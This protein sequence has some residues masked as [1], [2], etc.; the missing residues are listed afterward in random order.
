MV[1]LLQPYHRNFGKRLIK[2]PKLYFLDTGLASYLLGFQDSNLLRLSPCWGALFETLVITEWI[3]SFL[4]QGSQPPLYYWRSSDGIEVDLL[5]EGGSTFQAFEIKGGET[6]D[7]SFK[8]PLLKF[9]GLAS[10]LGPASPQVLANIASPQSL[11]QGIQ[12]VPWFTP[13]VSGQTDGIIAD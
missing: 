1:F 4:N 11:G 10:P 12:A 9:T 7:P 3:K 6:L 13:F 8:N 5:V 2:A